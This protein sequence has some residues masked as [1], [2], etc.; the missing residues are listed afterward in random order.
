M[1][2]WVVRRKERSNKYRPLA[3]Y[4]LKAD[5]K[6]A[7]NVAEKHPEKIEELEAILK[8]YVVNGGSTPGEVV[9]N[10]NNETSWHGLLI[11]FTVWPIAP[12]ASSLERGKANLSTSRR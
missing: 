7:T 8:A 10:H 2:R 12:T 5:I 1:K 11:P 4:D 9:Q 3:L 6:E